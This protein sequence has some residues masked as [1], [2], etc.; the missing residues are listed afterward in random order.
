MLCKVTTTTVVGEES[1]VVL[2][3]FNY[4]TLVPNNKA[5]GMEDQYPY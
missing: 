2:F 5:E 4:E 3:S 1:L